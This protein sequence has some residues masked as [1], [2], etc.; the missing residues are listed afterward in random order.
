MERV[1]TAFEKVRPKMPKVH[2]QR[3]LYGIKWYS[4]MVYM[5]FQGRA[6]REPAG[7]GLESSCKLHLPVI[8][9]VKE[10]LKKDFLY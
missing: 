7:L 9:T 3:C 6:Q 8:M 4:G 5:S 2:Y 10:N 1:F